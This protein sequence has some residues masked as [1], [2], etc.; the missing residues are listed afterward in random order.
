MPG[1]PHRRHTAFQLWVL[2]TLFFSC[3]DRA[4]CCNSCASY[5]VLR[6]QANGPF[7]PGE[8]VMDIF[9]LVSSLLLS[10]LRLESGMPP[11]PANPESINSFF[12]SMLSQEQNLLLIVVLLL[13][14]CLEKQPVAKVDNCIA[15]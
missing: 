12:G 15:S 14:E 1:T 4:S 8:V 13:Q 6:D 7:T 9:R 2:N 10:S 3:C 5:K 11:S